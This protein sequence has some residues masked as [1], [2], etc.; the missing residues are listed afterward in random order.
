MMPVDAEAGPGYLQSDGSN[1]M[2]WWIGSITAVLLSA[3]SALPGHRSAPASA[4]AV[5][6]LDAVLAGEYDNY[7]QVQREGV[8]VRAGTVLAVPHLR[9]QWRSLSRDHGGSLWLWRLQTVDAEQPADSLWLYLIS[10][11]DAGGVVLMPYRAIDPAAARAAFDNKQQKFH[12]VAEQWAE[13][14]A[15]ALRGDWKDASFSANADAAACGAL[16][17]GL[18]AS[19]ALLPLRLRIDGDMLHSVTYADQAR[20]A[21]AGID[22]RH[23]HW[24]TGWAAINGGGPKARADN[25]DW[26]MQDDIRLSSEGGHAALHWRDGAR[27]GY[28]LEL[29]R[30]TY[31]KR[32]L[33]VLQ[34]DVVDDASGQ[35]IDY[36]WTDPQ[37]RAIGLN[38]GWL[39]V[40]FIRTD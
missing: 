31:A 6:R 9:E 16:V 13:L 32:N 2:R 29:I 8:K 3:C 39:Q 33:S 14:A 34:L 15:C 17:P 19:A 23:V 10:P 37:S 7:A 5:S 22:A 35:V 38:L 40:G 12:F 30:T 18:G 26:H 28:S 36:V 11:G 1:M 27:S 21:N 24:F 4:Q 20:G 25:Q